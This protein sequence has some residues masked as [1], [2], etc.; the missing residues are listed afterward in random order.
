MVFG[1]PSADRFVFDEFGGDH[2]D[3]TPSCFVAEQVLGFI[4]HL[5]NELLGLAGIAG[6]SDR[7]L[8]DG[9]KILAATSRWPDRPGNIRLKNSWQHRSESHAFKIWFLSL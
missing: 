2:F 6:A 8:F 1:C 3:G 4:E 7:E 5:V 9:P